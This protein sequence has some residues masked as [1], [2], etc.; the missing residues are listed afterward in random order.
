MKTK[1]KITLTG[2][3]LGVANHPK[4]K[5]FLQHLATVSSEKAIL[6]VDK[7]SKWLHEHAPATPEPKA[8]K[9]KKPAA[10]KTAKPAAKKLAAKKA[11]AK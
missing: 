2:I 8:I 3:A 5:S 1:T 9:T 10:K 6:V 4:V 7:A 11:A